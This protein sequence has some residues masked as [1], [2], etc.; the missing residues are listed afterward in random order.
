M[1][2]RAE[3]E[4]KMRILLTGAA[5][6]I[7]SHL[8]GYLLEHTEHEIICLVRL[9]QVGW[10]KRIIEATGRI[11]KP[12]P[13]I[14]HHDLR[15]AINPSVANEI[16]DVDMIIHM[17]ASTHVDRSISDPMAFVL[18]NVVGT[19]NMLEFAREHCKKYYLQFST[20]EIFGPCP[21]GHPGY[22]ENDRPNP[23][24]PYAAAK[25][26]A[27]MMVRAY[28]NTYKL[29]A[30]ITRGMNVFGSMQDRNKFV[31]LVINNILNDKITY[32]HADPTKTKAGTRFYIHA[33]NVAHAIVFLMD[34]I[35]NGKVQMNL[36]DIPVFHFVGEKEVSNLEMVQAI[37]QIMGKEPKY[38]MID[39]HS[40]RAGHDMRYGMVDNNLKAFGWVIPQTFEQSLE[41]TVEW[42][43]ENRSW[44]GI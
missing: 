36:K 33:D 16:G 41:N 1:C 23:N 39:F 29:P 26:G 44:L 32:I 24:N 43:L 18:D 7:G 15:S 25:S 40:S 13:K 35:E 14:V 5:G 12:L 9:G 17:A 38:E 6:F 4:I 22:S 19:V 28:A 34:N 20:D 42:Y 27:E 3:D 10:Y 21:F 11:A 31:P 8:L 37:G 30:V 2:K